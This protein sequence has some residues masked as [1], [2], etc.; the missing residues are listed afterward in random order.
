MD[1]QYIKLFYFWPLCFNLY[2]TTF[3]S[4]KTL[5]TTYIWNLTKNKNNKAESVILCISSGLKLKNKERC[6]S[7]LK[8][9]LTILHRLHLLHLKVGGGKTGPKIEPYCPETLS[10]KGRSP[11]KKECLLSG[12]VQIRGVGEAIVNCPTRWSLLFIFGSLYW[13]SSWRW[14]PHNYTRS[15]GA[16]RAPTSSWRLFG[17]LDFV[18][19]ALQALRPCDPRHNDWIVC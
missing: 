4:F 3:I 7:Q 16:L 15:L 8:I 10:C 12:I 14:Q 18:L 19:R 2:F 5:I 13:S 9:G 17:P 11:I 6:G 1:S